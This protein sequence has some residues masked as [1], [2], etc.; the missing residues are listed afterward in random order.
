[1]SQMSL[2]GLTQE[3][4]TVEEL[5]AVAVRGVTLSYG[6]S[7]TILH[8][9][10]LNIAK[11]SF[12]CV[13]GPSGC[14]KTSLLRL[15]AGYVT[16]TEGEITVFGRK[17]AG[18]GPE[19]GVVFQHANLFPWL[20]LQKNVEF[21]L[22]MTEVSKAERKQ[23]VEQLLEQVGL[24]SSAQLLPHQLSGG[25]KQRA[26]LARTLITRPELILMDEPFAALD[27]IMRETLQEQLKEIWAGTG[28]TVF[29]ITHDVDEALLLA[30][31]IIVLGGS[32]GTVREDLVNPLQERNRGI[33]A[34]RQQNRYA[35]L[36]E[37]LVESLRK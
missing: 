3:T 34:I 26:A 8:D 19:V 1:M 5:D 32:P 12:V 28:K 11:G 29:F 15:L 21:G 18:P 17:L 16:P 31:R 7:S 10:H 24:T 4:T 13:L 22:K 30:T 36:R 9:I 37:R 14:G 33:S 27:A 6:S 2:H 23:R 20:S 25:M 35:A